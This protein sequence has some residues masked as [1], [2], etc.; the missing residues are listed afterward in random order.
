ME[1]KEKRK[2]GTLPVLAGEEGNTFG[3]I[4]LRHQTRE[5]EIVSSSPTLPVGDLDQSHSFLLKR[6]GK[7]GV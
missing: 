3:A 5:L 7:E 6:N 2:P 1:K 4:R